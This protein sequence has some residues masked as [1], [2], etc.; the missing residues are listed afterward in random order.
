MTSTVFGASDGWT[1]HTRPGSAATP[2]RVCADC[3]FAQ[4][5]AV[6][7]RALCTHPTA[8]LRGAAVPAARPGC[9]DLVVRLG[10][11]FALHTF[12]PDSVRPA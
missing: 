9:E 10:P 11:D 8:D 4:V 5:F 2:R 1:R 6:Q 12:S 7:P 3:L